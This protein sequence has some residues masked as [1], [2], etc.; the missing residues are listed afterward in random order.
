MHP[1]SAGLRRELSAR[2]LPG[3]LVP[4]ALSA[5]TDAAAPANWAVPARPMRRSPAVY[6]N[7]GGPGPG[8]APDTE[9][10]HRSWPTTSSPSA[11]PP[12]TGPTPGRRPSGGHG[13][14]S[15]ARPWWTSATR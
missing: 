6:P 11:C 10:D 5:R 3:R 1:R 12:T 15:W 13:S 4:K 9:Q 14:A 7:G 8:R 2:R